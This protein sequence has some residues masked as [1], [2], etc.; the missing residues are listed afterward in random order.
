MRSPFC[1]Q[2]DSL[3]RD[4]ANLLIDSSARGRRTTGVSHLTGEMWKE[5]T[6]D[7]FGRVHWISVGG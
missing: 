5:K 1:E 2:M 4:S 6:Q 3:T 7:Q